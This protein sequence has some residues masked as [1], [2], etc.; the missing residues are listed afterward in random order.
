MVVVYNCDDR[1]ASI[2]AVSV[3]SLFECNKAVEDLTVYLIDNGI[4]EENMRKVQEIATTYCRKIVSLPMPDLESLLGMDVAVPAKSN[5]IATCGRLFVTSLLPKNIDKILYF[6]CDTIF[7]KSIKPLWEIDLG[8]YFAGMMA[9]T[10]GGK[11]RT[12]L[13]ISEKGIYYNSGVALINLAL[14]REHGIERK[15]MKYLESQG[16]YVPWPDQGV[17]NAVLDGKI[18]CLPC[19][20]NVHTT[21]FSF[22]YDTL[23]KV[24]KLQWYYAKDEVEQSLKDSG[25]VHFTT[26]FSIPL[27][28]WY[29][30]CNHPYTKSFLK[31]REMTPW[32]DEPLWKDDRS[33]TARLFYFV[34]E[35]FSKIAPKWLSVWVTRQFYVTLRPFAYKIK[36]RKFIR[37]NMNRDSMQNNHKGKGNPN[38]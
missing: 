26:T 38:S 11:Y 3:L 31:F 17:F 34:F 19:A 32:K 36:K 22:P 14:W 21:L 4:R 33:E 7:L 16:G 10:M 15:F 23:L 30:G 37:N 5:R 29:E 18:K 24:K 6:D 13:G 35:R 12:M 1:Y 27:R 2:F 9:D 8:E 25:M 20:Y 28:P